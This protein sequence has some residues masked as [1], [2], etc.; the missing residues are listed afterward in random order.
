MGRKRYGFSFTFIPMS[1]ITRALLCLQFRSYLLVTIPAKND[2]IP[3]FD[4][5]YFAVQHSDKKRRSILWRYDPSPRTDKN[6]RSR[7]LVYDDAYKRKPQR[8]HVRAINVSAQ[9]I[10]CRKLFLRSWSLRLKDRYVQAHM[11]VSS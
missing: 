4:F 10:L 2:G 5:Y 6:R 8:M 9:C 3:L 1:I 7:L 11:H